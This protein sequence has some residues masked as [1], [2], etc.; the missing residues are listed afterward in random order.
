M[1]VGLGLP[2]ARP[3][4]LLEWAR[5][6]DDS[7]FTTLGLLDRL[8][9]DNPEPLVT[10]ASLAGATARIRLQTEVLLAPL[11]EPALLAKQAATLDRL[12]GGRFTLG[13]GVGGRADEFDLVGA[14]LRTRG[15]RLDEQ[16]MRDIWS[17]GSVGPAPHREGGPE[18]LFGAFAEPALER[19]A[20]WGDGFLCAA[21]L[22]FAGRLFESVE[23]FWSRAGRAG[24]PRMVAQVNVAVGPESTVDEARAAIAAYYGFAGDLARRTAET[25][26][27]TPAAVREAVDEFTA[28]G[29]DE[30]M[31]YCW[32][33]DTDQVGRLAEAVS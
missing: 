7:P 19:V 24:R 32:S 33:P 6:A 10:L 17:G 4:A 20:R 13:L 18:V 5:R 22:S 2:I 8:V 11:R 21:P 3:E 26:L 12:S 27:T 28:L 23:R 31:L 25:M 9:W 16:I 29:A 30:V 15:R 14:D 1:S